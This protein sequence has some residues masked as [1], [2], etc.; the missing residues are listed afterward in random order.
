MLSPHVAQKSFN[1]PKT[2]VA[3]PLIVFHTTERIVEIAL[4]ALS[5]I[6]RIDSAFSLKKLLTVVQTHVATLEIPCQIT[7]KTELIIPHTLEITPRISPELFAK[8]SFNCPKIAV[9]NET[10]YPQMVLIKVEIDPQTVIA[11][12]LIDSQHEVMKFLNVS[13]VFHK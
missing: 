12:S 10:K 13:F 8:K 5:K 6:I 7:D 9:P 11:T 3:N 2:V 1:A 4:H